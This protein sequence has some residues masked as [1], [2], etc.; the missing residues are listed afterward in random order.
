MIAVVRIYVSSVFLFLALVHPLLAQ[1]QVNGIGGKQTK[2]QADRCLEIP[3]PLPPGSK[4]FYVNLS[5]SAD[6]LISTYLVFSD[7]SL[8]QPMYSAERICF[9]DRVWQAPRIYDDAP[10]SLNYPNVRAFYYAGL[11]YQGHPTKVFAYAGFP[12]K[13]SSASK[14][15][16]VVLVHGGGGTAFPQW[17]KAWNDEGF[18]AIAMDL[19]GHQPSSSHDL[20]LL[21]SEHVLGGPRNVMFEDIGKSIRDQWLYHAV[22]DVYIA[23]SLLASDERVDRRRIGVTGISW[24]GIIT[25]IAVGN[26][27]CFAFAI[28]VYGCGF[29]HT[30][31]AMYRK[32]FTDHVAKL[33]DPS[34]WLRLIKTPT[35]WINGESDPIF[36]ID[37]TTKSARATPNSHLTIIPDLLHSHIHGWSPREI[38]AFT[39]SVVSGGKGPLRIRRQPTWNDPTIEIDVTG[40][41]GLKS[42]MLISSQDTLGYDAQNHLTTVWLR[43]LIDPQVFSA[44]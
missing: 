25:S 5:D 1:E 23:Y 6:N 29:L 2:L 37:A 34:R 12:A 4:T 30:S 19:E 27:D 9:D 44:E 38:V 40:S 11:D 35:F 7:T 43:R 14:V 21:L 36:S 33:W 22:A 31:K 8:P 39:K 32:T 10:D 26:A 20:S 3:L 15:P 28:P 18:A 17:V 41:Y 42:V 24:G 13:A 16:A